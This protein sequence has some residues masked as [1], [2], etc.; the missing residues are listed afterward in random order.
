MTDLLKPYTPNLN[1]VLSFVVRHYFS[2]S[3]IF[4]HQVTDTKIRKA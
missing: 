2:L 3:K 4:N 1:W